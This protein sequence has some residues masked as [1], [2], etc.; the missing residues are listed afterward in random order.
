MT[1]ANLTYCCQ[2]KC[3]QKLTSSLAHSRKATFFEWSICISAPP[4][5]NGRDHACFLVRAQIYTSRHPTQDYCQVCQPNGCNHRQLTRDS[6]HYICFP[7]KMP[8]VCLSWTGW[9]Q[10]L[11]S[12]I[13][14]A[15][16]HQE[17]LSLHQKRTLEGAICLRFLTKPRT[18]NTTLY[19]IYAS[20]DIVEWAHA[21][22]TGQR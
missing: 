8:Y 4:T 1:I 6:C 19:Y 22:R 17:S 10:T 7:I 5:P 2:K 14:L 11:I 21:S 20:K 9:D 16:G 18:K 3:R 15:G 13:I 12:P